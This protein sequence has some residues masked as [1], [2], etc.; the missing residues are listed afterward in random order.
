MAETPNIDTYQ[1]KYP[2]ALLYT[3]GNEVGLPYGEFGNSEVGHLNIG[4]GRIVYQPLLR[5]SNEIEAGHL[6]D[7]AVM[8][9]IIAHL[10]KYK[11]ALHL[12][13]LLSAGGAHSHIE[14]LLSLLEWCKNE[15][16]KTV[17]IHVF[18]DGRDAPPQSAQEY[19]DSLEAKI[20]ELGINAKIASIS[21]RF[22]SMDRNKKWD[23][24]KK[25]YDVII[26]NSKV[27]SDSIPQ[28]LSET[29][30]KGKSDEFLEP[31]SLTD[32]KGNLIGKVNNGDALLF[33]NIRPDRSRQIL[34]PFVSNRFNSF[35]IKKFSNLHVATLTEYDPKIKAEVAFPEKEI[36]HPLGEILSKKGLK[37]FRIAEAVKYPH[38]TYFFN[39]GQEKPFK[40]EIRKLI[41]SIPESSYTKKPEM[42]AEN[43]KE[44]VLKRLDE[45]KFDF[46]LINFANSDMIG[47][48][49]NL[50][51]AIKAIEFLDRCIGEIVE[52]IL[53]IGGAIFITAD[54]GNSE[55]MVNS[56]S[57]ENDTEHNIYPAPFMLIIKSLEHKKETKDFKQ[58]IS[59]PIGALADIAPTILDLMNI[60]KPEEMTGISL[61][62][63]LK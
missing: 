43:V 33:F 30:G 14:H 60:E 62:N 52:K 13:G 53:S 37:Q 48:T 42:S 40:G 36:E 50:K 11:G 5:V 17:Y 32:E 31:H 29:Y 20:K 7:N 46:Y 8:K 45:G 16:I 51:A 19:I 47:H 26:G 38:V 18:T 28:I 63:S 55:E 25:A 39:G 27:K 6:Y 49:G 44:E 23:R 22:Y 54:H 41:P 57:G 58:T 35:K 4:S 3:A 56:Q 59:E 15:K 9:K 34:S 24:T 1:R 21:G 61:L 2:K 12:M 10:K